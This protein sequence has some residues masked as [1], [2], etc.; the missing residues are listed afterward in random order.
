MCTVSLT[1]VTSH[2]NK[3]HSLTTLSRPSHSCSSHPT[4]SP[5]LLLSSPPLPLFLSLPFLLPHQSARSSLSSLQAS[6]S[7]S[8]LQLSAARDK[9][10]AAESAATA[11]KSEVNGLQSQL[12]A[13]QGDAAIKSVQMQE[14]GDEL[15]V[16]GREN[17]GG[18]EGGREG[19]KLCGL[20]GKER[21]SERVS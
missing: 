13:A 17:W 8:E 2:G 11:A 12:A 5:P 15:A 10:A 19:V 1:I 3:H 4:N 6:L 21:V 16:S 14:M 7:L 9:Q 18:R 20:D